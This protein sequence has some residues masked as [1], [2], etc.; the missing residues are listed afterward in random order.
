M[1]CRR[2]RR[3]RHQLTLVV[4]A[5]TLAT[6]AMGATD[7]TDV[8]TLIKGHND[9]RALTSLPALTWDAA[10]E[11]T[12]TTWAATCAE[13]H[14]DDATRKGAGENLGWGWPT[15]NATAVTAG[16]I[17]E[18]ADLAGG[19]C[20]A[21]KQCGHY[22][23]IVSRTIGALGCATK[24]Q[25]PSSKVQGQSVMQIWVCHYS[26]SSTNATTPSPAPGNSTTAPTSTPINATATPTGLGFGNDTGASP[27]GRPAS[28]TTTTIPANSAGGSTPT[29]GYATA[30]PARGAGSTPRLLP[31]LNAVRALRQSIPITNKVGTRYDSEPEPDTCHDE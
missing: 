29:N 25:C 17:N 5:L 10:L 21:G 20:A 16:W 31:M 3:G 26:N 14:S 8:A 27:A 28:P 11:A 4:A 12:A 18:K 2:D 15:I 7:P 30:M 9:E 19:V 23:L 6:M 24:L 13:A 1:P 22:E